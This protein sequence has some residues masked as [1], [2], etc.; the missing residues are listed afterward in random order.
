MNTPEEQAE[1]DKAQ[2][3]LNERKRVFDI[4]VA[5]EF[6]ELMGMPQ[7]RRFVWLF[8]ADC[9]VWQPIY[10]SDH[11]VMS[12]REGKRQMGLNLLT[13]IQVHCPDMYQKMTTENATNP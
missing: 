4:M 10:D 8:L 3:A 1:I 12:L 6:R 5:E 13:K 11:S 7:F 2:Q 9:M